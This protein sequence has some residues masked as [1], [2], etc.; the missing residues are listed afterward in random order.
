MRRSFLLCVAPWVPPPRADTKT[1]VPPLPAGE[2]GGS[3]GVSMG[4]SHRLATTPY[5]KRMALSTYAT[6]M[7]EAETRYPMSPVRSGEYDMRYTVVP[8]PDHHKHRP[9]LE[10]GEARRIPAMHIPVILLVNLFDD[11]KGDWVG[12]KFETVYVPQSLARTSLLPQ[13][14]AVYATPEAYALLGLPVKH[15]AIHREIPKT[16]EQYRRVLARQHYNEE[17]W[18]YDIEYLFRAYADGPP[19]LRPL[20][21]GEDGAVGGEAEAA[22]IAGMTGSS[23]GAA[24]G[25]ASSGA[26]GA[27]GTRGPKKLRK[28]RK[29]K[30]F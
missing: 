24:A 5:W 9:L 4:Y 14:F 22:W 20:E 2:V 7:M 21:E 11:A 13:R 10:V 12:K 26:A 16:P 30:L 6:R 29:I 23:P 17:R 28:A 27:T 1:T 18:Q 25:T 15:H 8:Y 3:F 19:E